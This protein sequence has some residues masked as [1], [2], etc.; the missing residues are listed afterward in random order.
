MSQHQHLLTALSADSTALPPTDGALALAGPAPSEPSPAFFG[1]PVPPAQ[2]LRQRWLPDDPEGLVPLRLIGLAGPRREREGRG[3]ATAIV[4]TIRTLIRCPL[5]HRLA[6]LFPKQETGRPTPPAAYWLFY[7]ALA[8]EISSFSQADQEI[9][10]HYDLVLAEFAVQGV[11]LPAARP[12]TTNPVPSYPAYN[13]WRRTHVTKANRFPELL[14]EFT[15]ASLELAWLIRD[16]EGHATGDP[17]NPSLGEILS[18]D[19]TVFAPPSSVREETT[20]DEIA[21]QHIT[22]YPGSRARTPQTEKHVRDGRGKPRPHQQGSD[23]K[24]HK[25]HG[26]T[27][28]FYHLALSTKGYATYTRVILDVDIA[29]RGEA[30]S[31]AAQPMLDRVLAAA[32]NH[33]QAIAYDGQI[34]PRHA[35]ELM[36]RH[37]TYVIN[38]NALRSGTRKDEGDGTDATAGISTRLQGHHKGKTVK[39]YSTPLRSQH[40]QRADGSICTHH[41]VSDDGAV[42]PADRAGGTGTQAKTGPVLAPTA[43]RRLWTETGYRI[44]LEYTIACPHGD[45]TYRARLTDTK[46][47]SDGSVAWSSTL[48]AHRVIPGAWEE[49]F[50]TAFGARNQSEALYSWLERR[51]YH[52]D[53]VASWG[54]DAQLVDLLC[55]ALLHN[56]E[57]WAHYAYRHGTTAGS[58]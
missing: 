26:P 38:H 44:E 4:D 53:R 8:R 3:G 28:G 18:G 2:E 37:G 23:Y 49:R 36:A 27:Q 10:S 57:A 20:L 56:A 6:T 22:T 55:A 9:E 39:T 29:K 5:L 41:L 13:R 30:E 51:Y 40:H 48:A 7:G 1:E 42:Y 21:N 54:R 34:Y 35:L 24:E 19:A 32:P 11:T 16:A 46:P 43:L 45:Q 58:H 15:H 33:F 31:T 50:K 17:L 52:K 12:G 47:K 14:R 25:K